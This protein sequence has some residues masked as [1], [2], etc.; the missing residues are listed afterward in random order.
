MQSDAMGYAMSFQAHVR[1]AILLVSWVAAVNAA[2]H[3]CSMHPNCRPSTVLDSQS[4]IN[5]CTTRRRQRHTPVAG[6]PEQDGVAPE[7]K[8][9]LL[10]E[11]YR[12][13]AADGWRLD[14]AGYST[15][16]RVKMQVSCCPFVQLALAKR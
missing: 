8:E 2:L 1:S 3:Y 9:G 7:S 16:F 10:W 14:A 11:T 4:S 12:K 5:G 6:P 13:F 15:A